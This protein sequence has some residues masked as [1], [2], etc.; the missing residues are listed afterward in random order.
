M[1]ALINDLGIKY[2]ELIKIVC[3][4][5]ICFYLFN[6]RETFEYFAWID[7]LAGNF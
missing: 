1:W 5:K 4:S 7:F 6:S 2:S 3:L